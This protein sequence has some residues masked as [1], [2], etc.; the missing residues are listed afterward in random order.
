MKERDRTL[1]TPLHYCAENANTNCADK[2]L[3]VA[4]ELVNA[5]DE[6]GYCPLHLGV[7][8]GNKPFINLLIAKGANVNLHDNEGHSAVHWAIGKVH[9][10]IFLVNS[11]RF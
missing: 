5:Q 2:I 7:I 9:S 8:S 3:R 10:F 1:K 6:N 4:P 11:Q